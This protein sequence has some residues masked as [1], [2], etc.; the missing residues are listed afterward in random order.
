VVITRGFGEAA[1]RVFYGTPPRI[2]VLIEPS[3]KAEGA[4]IEGLLFQQAS[5]NMQKILSD[6][7]LGLSR[8]CLII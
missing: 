8:K 3:R 4:V 7:T 6:R 5:E 1:G 2:D